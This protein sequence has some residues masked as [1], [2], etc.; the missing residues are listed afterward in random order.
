MFKTRKGASAALVGFLCAALAAPVFANDK[1]VG[2]LSG[3]LGT[4][5]KALKSAKE[6]QTLIVAGVQKPRPKIKPKNLA[7]AKVPTRKELQR[8]PK[9]SG[10]SEWA[11]L[12]EALYFEARGESIP[13]IFAVAEVIVNR[14]ASG[15]FP[16][17]V[18]GVIT[19]GAHRRN[20]CQFSYKCDGAA[21]VYHEPKAHAM[22]GKI[23]KMVLDGR[24]KSLTKGATFYH[25]HTV[26]PRWA[27]QFRRTAQIGKHLFY[28]PG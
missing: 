17:S 13:G 15:R 19:Q 26:N 20:A 6:D 10:G 14:K 27:R 3:V 9:A 5:T 23:A 7:I 22:V 1:I 18:C 8:M 21:E 28:K 2:D 16:N 4:E 11:C 12:T 25:S 24:T